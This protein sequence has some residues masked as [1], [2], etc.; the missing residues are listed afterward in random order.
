MKLKTRKSTTARQEPEPTPPAG[1]GGGVVGVWLRPTANLT[2]LGN[3]TQAV[4]EALD[5]FAEQVA[6]KGVD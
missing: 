2:C 6:G 4:F 5:R 1:D 3:N